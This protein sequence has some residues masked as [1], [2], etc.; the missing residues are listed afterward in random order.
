MKST[1]VPMR[2]LIA[3]SLAIALSGGALWCRVPAAFAQ[4]E[5]AS[6]SASRERLAREFTDPLTTLPQVFVQDAYTPANY[7]TD[8]PA[9]RVLLRAIVPRVPRFT[10]FPFVQLVRPTFSLVTVPTGRGSQTRTEFGDMQLF[11]AFVLPWSP[12]EGL[13]IGVGPAFVF[14][15]ASHKSAGQGA[16]QV[17]PMLGALYKG[18]PWLLAGCLIQNPISFAYTSPDRRRVSTFAF[19]PIVLVAL[20]G[21]WY[22]KSADSSWLL[23][24]QRGTATQLPLS[25]GIGRVLVREGLPPLNFYVSGEWMAY[26]QF[27]P[28]APQ[29]TVRFGMTVAFPELRRWWSEGR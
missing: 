1:R 9:N 29:T 18:T 20:P 21:G 26:R 17:G 16:W 13:R 8:A 14:P 28:V 22:V 4:D 23:N 7:G 11:D 19:Q 6:E 25:F 2:R 15:T 10:L 3:A 24:W 12:V 5:D 27:A